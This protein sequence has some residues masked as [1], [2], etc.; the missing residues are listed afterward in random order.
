MTKAASRT[1]ADVK[2]ARRNAIPEG[3]WLRCPGK[4]C[5]AR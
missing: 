2:P 4:D 1:W 3:L 5:G